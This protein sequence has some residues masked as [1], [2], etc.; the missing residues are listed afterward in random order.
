MTNNILL[1]LNLGSTSTKLAAFAGDVCRFT[2][3]IRHTAAELAPF[4]DIRDQYAFRKAAILACL[5]GHGLGLQDLTAIV[6]RGGLFAPM[7]GGV[8]AIDDKLAADARS[9]RYGKHACNLSCEIAFDLARELGIPALTVDPVT[10][11]ELCDEA[12]FTGLPQ[13]RRRSIYHALNQRAIARRLAADLG[14]TTTD[15]NAIVVHLGGGISVGAHE[16]GRVIDVNNALDGDGPFS[17]ERAGTLPAGDLIALC[18][19]GRHTR[20]DLMKLLAGKGGLVAHLGTTDGQELEKRIVAGDADARRA[21]AA[22]AF[23]IA[24]AIGA[25]ACVLSGRVDAIAMTGGLAH[26]QRLVEM[27]SQRVAFIAPIR[28]YPG[29]DEIGA[30]AAGALRVLAGEERAK[31]YD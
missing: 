4:A 16:R 30:L 28:L 12:R 8:Y 15:V 7:P 14:K 25:A 21:V 3:T 1:V 29:E 31:S 24:K 22:M 9:S 10:S 18:F 13:I 11:D 23:G 27:I 6:S 2:E 5:D 17:P 20:E 26:W 19:S